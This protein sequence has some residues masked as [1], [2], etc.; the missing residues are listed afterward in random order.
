[1]KVIK[2]NLLDDGLILLNNTTEEW[3]KLFKRKFEIEHYEEIY[4]P[5][6]EQYNRMFW[7]VKRN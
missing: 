7:I 4:Y 6:Y 3:T 2:G 5:Q 1:M